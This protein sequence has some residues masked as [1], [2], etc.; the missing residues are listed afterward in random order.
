MRVPQRAARFALQEVILQSSLLFF[1]VACIP[2]ETAASDS[3]KAA[4]TARRVHVKHKVIH[5]FSPK[6]NAAIETGG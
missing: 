6:L 3:P 4:P 1:R 5:S 2:Y